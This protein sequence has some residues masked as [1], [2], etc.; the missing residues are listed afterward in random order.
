MVQGNDR[1]EVMN[2]SQLGGKLHEN[3]QYFVLILILDT[4]WCLVCRMEFDVIDIH[5]RNLTMSLVDRNSI[6]SLKTRNDKFLKLWEFYEIQRILSFSFIEPNIT[7]EFGQRNLSFQFHQILLNSAIKQL[8]SIHYNRIMFYM[9][10]KMFE[11]FIR[12]NNKTLYL[13]AL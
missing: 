9:V 5:R 8:L 11:G 3:K 10:L 6:P 4:E 13:R 12:L 7:K 1:S 2:P